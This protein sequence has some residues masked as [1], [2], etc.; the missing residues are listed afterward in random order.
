MAHHQSPLWL[1][2]LGFTLNCGWHTIEIKYETKLIKN[3]IYSWFKL[4]FKVNQVNQKHKALVSFAFLPSITSLL[5][6]F[7]LTNRP[8]FKL[9]QILWSSSTWPVIFIGFA[10]LA[11]YLR[12]TTVYTSFKVEPNIF[13]SFCLRLTKKGRQQKL[14]LVHSHFS[15]Q[16]I[17]ND[18]LIFKKTHSH[19]R[20]C[21]TKKGQ[22]W[23]NFVI[24]W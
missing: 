4:K 16:S 1:A 23:C 18:C 9:L 12:Q 15:D 24:L 5:L 2:V 13:F 11:L 20:A 7:F 3:V 19:I 21:L 6:L 14:P 8:F 22:F 10:F 17:I